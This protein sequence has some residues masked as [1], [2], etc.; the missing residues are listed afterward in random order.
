MLL[1]QLVL[2]TF[3]VFAMLKTLT[4]FRHGQ[5]SW[6]WLGFWLLFWF[7]V[8]V[9]SLLPQTATIL[10]DLVGVGRGADLIVYLAL[11]VLFY[12]T[13]RLFVKHELL[14][15]HLTTLVRELALKEHDAQHQ[16]DTD[17]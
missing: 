8:V 9:V 15:R 17:V 16:K 3:A 10:A 14:E 2:V 5:L 4:Q 6:A 11:V 1:I 13:F 12:L 7:A